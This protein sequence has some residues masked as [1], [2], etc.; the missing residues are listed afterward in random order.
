MLPMESIYP[1]FE[2]GIVFTNNMID[3]KRFFKKKF[4]IMTSEDSKA[5]AGTL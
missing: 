4:E 5:N 3:F 1:N 2:A